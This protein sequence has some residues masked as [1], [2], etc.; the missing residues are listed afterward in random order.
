MLANDAAFAA[1]K[2]TI[3]RLQRWHVIA[4]V[5]MPDHL[6]AVVWPSKRDEAIGEF[7]ALLKRWMRTELDVTWQW[8][9]GCFDHLLRSAESAQ[10]K[11][12]YMRE[13]PVRGGLV[14]RW[15]DWPYMIGF[16]SKDPPSGP[17]GLQ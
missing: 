4:A 10:E 9:P 5:L 12:E 15:E 8:Q 3:A 2:N 1:F 7:S 13:N 6:H 11:W 17:L 16:Q 14:A